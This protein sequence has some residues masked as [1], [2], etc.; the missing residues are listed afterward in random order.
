MVKPLVHTQGNIRE[1]VTEREREK[2]KLYWKKVLKF[3]TEVSFKLM[4][5]PHLHTQKWNKKGRQKGRKKERESEQQK[6]I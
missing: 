4:V 5:S 2:R 3:F 1:Q 6:G